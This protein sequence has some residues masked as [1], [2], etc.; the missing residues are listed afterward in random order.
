[1]SGKP[2]LFSVKS[3]P[4]SQFPATSPRVLHSHETHIYVPTTIPG[5]DLWSGP[6]SGNR[7]DTGRTLITSHA[8]NR[9]L[10]R[11]A[12]FVGGLVL[13]LRKTEAQEV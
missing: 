1:M 4:E 5:S 3:M 8:R 7:A 11:L 12:R 10:V 6:F 9:D 13:Q 2:T